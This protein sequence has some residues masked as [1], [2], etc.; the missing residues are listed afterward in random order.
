MTRHDVRGWPRR[1]QVVGREV[2]HQRFEVAVGPCQVHRLEAFV[3]LLARQAALRKGVPAARRCT[4]PGRRPRRAFE[5]R[6]RHRA[7]ALCPG[8][9]ITTV[10]PPRDLRPASGW[11]NGNRRCRR[12]PGSC[13][14]SPAVSSCNA[15]TEKPCCPGSRSSRRDSG[16]TRRRRRPYGRDPRVV[17]AVSGWLA[18]S[19]THS[20]DNT[21][22]TRTRASC[23]PQDARGLRHPQIW[24]APHARTVFTDHQ[25][26]TGVAQ[27]HGLGVGLDQR[28]HDPCLLLT[29]P[30]CGQLLLAEVNG[31]GVRT[32]PGE[33][34][35]EESRTGTQLDH[36]QS[37]EVRQGRQPALGG[38]EQPHRTPSRSHIE[39]A[40]ASVYRW[41][42]IVHS[43]RLRSSS[44]V[45]P[46]RRS[47][48]STCSLEPFAWPIPD[49]RS[50]N[51]G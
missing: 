33:R 25:V 2:G 23:R 16:G 34:C 27:R 15:S 21:L 48:C 6:S 49:S 12:T 4:C 9:G 28:K 42:T 46:R 19:G 36:R 14:S 18:Q 5:D 40:A 7:Y 43:A 39:R 22:L 38:A 13:A 50:S 37:G 17:F 10:G 3:I 45:M 51:H 47:Q 29:A 1:R 20:V 35:G 31:D 32:G 44:A 26:G 24:I 11:P 8:L 41:L 30:G